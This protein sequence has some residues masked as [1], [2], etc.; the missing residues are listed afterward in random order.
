MKWEEAWSHIHSSQQTQRCDEEID[1]EA[2]H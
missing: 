2:A 1:K